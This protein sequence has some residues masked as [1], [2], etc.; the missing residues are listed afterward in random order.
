MR[1][2]ATAFLVLSSC[3]SV[4]AQRPEDRHIDFSL[5][6]RLPIG[7]IPSAEVVKLIGAPTEILA[8]KREFKT[9][10]AWLYFEN[11]GNIRTQR[12]SLLI[13]KKTGTV[14]TALW[15]LKEGDPFYSK[16]LA[17]AHF[18]DA[19]FVARSTGAVGKD[20]YSDDQFYNDPQKGISI[21]VR[22]G[23]LH[24]ESI[25]FAMPLPDAVAT[26]N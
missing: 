11:I 10:E 19:Q 15:S 12:L 5:I 2:I 17:L 18:K 23:S 13:D 14:L 22:E 4:S 9:Q 16:D 7:K 6:E 25:S 8:L 21:Y 24:A 26:R 20:Y 1:L 3:A